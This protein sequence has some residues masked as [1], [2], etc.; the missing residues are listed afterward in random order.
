[1]NFGNLSVSEWIYSFYFLTDLSIKN[2]IF[3][4]VIFI[5]LPKKNENFEQENYM[6]KLC[7]L[8][9]EIIPLS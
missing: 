3:F 4:E 8:V 9:G 6:K 1:M 2:D 7:A 5:V